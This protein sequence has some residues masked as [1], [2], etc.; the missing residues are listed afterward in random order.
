MQTHCS[1]NG[2][3]FVVSTTIYL[4]RD[5]FFKA[6]ALRLNKTAIARAAIAQEVEK[7]EKERGCNADNNAPASCPCKEANTLEPNTD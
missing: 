6:R 2:E 7:M 1:L 3:K 4:P 5:L